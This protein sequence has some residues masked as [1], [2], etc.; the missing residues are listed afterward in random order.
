MKNFVKSSIAYLLMV[1]FSAVVCMVVGL[2]V[3]TLWS[4]NAGVSVFFFGTLLMC[5]ALG[6]LD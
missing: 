3:C 6:A 2:A 5:L 4:C 1:L